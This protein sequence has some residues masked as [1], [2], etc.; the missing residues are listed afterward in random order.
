MP[1]HPGYPFIPKSTAHLRAGDFWAIPLRR[2]GWYACG[3]VLCVWPEGRVHVVIGLLDW[4][5]PAP[6]SAE[7]VDGA[8]V[9]E[10]GHAHVKTIA[11]TG[12]PLLGNHP[13][14]LGEG[15]ALGGS[16]WGYLFI[17]DR[18]HSHFGRHFPEHPNPATERPAP[19]QSDWR[20]C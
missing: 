19:L 5:E 10:F 16:T 1:K 12:G 9:L 13:L 17:E 18:A 8:A 15:Y 11:L 7:S 20:G 2:G 3:R 14:A 6:P 4:C